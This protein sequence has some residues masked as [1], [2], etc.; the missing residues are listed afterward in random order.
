LL[1]HPGTREAAVIVREDLPGDKL[2]VAY[3][4]PVPDAPASPG[5]LRAHLQD[6]LPEYMIPSAFVLVDALPLTPNGKLDRERLPALGAD[7]FGAGSG[8]AP[9]RPPEADLLQGIWAFTLR[10]ERVGIHDD[11]FELGGHSLSAIQ[12]V[13]RM[14]ED[15]AVEGPLHVLFKSPTVA[16]IAAYLADASPRAAVPPVVPVPHDRALPLSF[17]QQRLWF[18]DQL[19][20]GSSFYNISHGVRFQGRLD[21]PALWGSLAEVVRRHEALRTVFSTE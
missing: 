17:A 15:F 2:L 14:R 1:R 21:I 7:R 5:E 8:Y 19:V 4:G 12:T 9:P 16:G 6:G 3:V 13:S 18:L 10:I 20:E 11:F